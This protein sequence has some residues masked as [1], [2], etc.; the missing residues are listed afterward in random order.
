M[1]AV[2]FD[3]EKAY[4]TTWK[5]GIMKDLHEMDLRGRLPMFVENFLRDRSFNV[6]LGATK[7]DEFE[8]EMGVPQ[9]S[10][11]SVTLFSIKINSIVNC[12]ASD[13]NCSLYVD[14]FLICFG[15]KKMATIER[16]L[17]QTLN[18]LQIWADTN[19]FK[20]SRSKTVCMHFCRS[21]HCHDDPELTLGGFPI[22]V[23]EKTKFLGLIFDR[24][25]TF[26]PHIQQLKTKCLR[27]LDLLKVL[28][29]SDW[30]ADKATLL[31][32]YRSLIR[33][34]LD[35]G[36]MVYGSAC[37]T[38]LKLLDPVHTQ[39]IRICLGAFRS[40]PRESLCVE[41]DE[42]P[43]TLRRTKLALQYCL[44]V[45]SNPTNPAYSCVFHPKFQDAFEGNPERGPLGIR[46]K[47]HFENLGLDTFP[48]SQVNL[49]EFAFWDHHSPPVILDLAEHK[50]DTT[51]P[52]FYKSKYL[53][54]RSR[55]EDYETIYTDGS[56]D[57]E[58]AGAAVY[59]NVETY[60]CRLPDGATV[61]SAELKALLLALEHI[62][63]S[64]NDKFIIFSDS[65]SA[66]QALQ[67]CDFRNSLLMF[68]LKE[69]KEL[70]EDHQK[71]IILCWIPS[72]I[73][74]PG[75]EAADKAAKR[76][77][78]LPITE[79]AVHYEDYKLH[80]KNYINRLWQRRWDG[81]AG[82]KL[83]KVEPVLGAHRSPGH[84]SR[85]E[86]I[87]LSRL[88]IG[89]TR[90][91]HSYRMNNEDVPRCV[92]CDCNLTVEHILVECGDF[93]E[94]RQRYYDA[95]SLQQLFHEIN[96]TYVFDFL[97]EIGL[98]YRI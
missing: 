68:F 32:V 66:L 28:S 30:G 55:Y 74:I 3:M 50:K 90:L 80:I 51:S 17:Q 85:R 19:G 11:L 25:L 23:V 93:A 84:L 38:N 48:V 40:S 14:D 18:K 54:I 39:A 58:R 64:Q 31:M 16:K 52:A 7:S 24:R 89:H 35:Y 49:Q 41:A 61:F 82:N 59:T 70:T 95:E 87:V 43:L 97:H 62:R 76:A 1:V 4:D 79:M 13:T 60:S 47:P 69:Y 37:Q 67:G 36:C 33:S 78:D 8:Q 77:L 9:G 29:H 20:F 6:R 56:K 72:H 5:Y 2:F 86:E 12:L 10:I 63:K 34:K 65:L 44:K 22:P 42:P 73:G 83:N 46:M 96:V 91:T 26:K 57:E 15:G 88:R 53:E 27:A 94:V 45:K 21:T 75:N 71:T 98:F 81:C 92:A